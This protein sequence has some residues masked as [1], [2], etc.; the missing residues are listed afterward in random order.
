MM[1]RRSFLRLLAASSAALTFPSVVRAQTLGLGGG[2]APSN[3]L[4]MGFIG[5]GGQGFGV[6]N[7]F[8]SNSR[9]QGVAVCDVD[10]EFLKKAKTRID[11]VNKVPAAEKGVPTYADLREMLQ[12]SDIDA[13]TI[14]TP[15]HWHALA[16]VYAAQAGKHI[17]LEKPI[18][19]N[20][21][22]GRIMVQAVRQAGVVC[23]IGNQQRSSGEFIRFIDLVRNGY[24]GEIKVIKVGLPS[25]KDASKADPYASMEVPPTLD[26]ERWLGPAPLVPY[27]KDRVHFKWRWN[28]DYGGGQLTDWIGHHYDIAA[29]ALRVTDQQP[30]ALEKVSGKFPL[31]SSLNNVATDYAFLARYASGVVIDVSSSY[32]GGAYAEGTEGWM[33]VNR[34]VTDYSSDLLRRMVIPSQQSLAGEWRKDHREHFV[35]AVL[36]GGL[37]NSPIWEG[38]N[39]ATVAHLGNVALQTNRSGLRWDP[40]KEQL[41]DAPEGV[42]FLSRAYRGGYALPT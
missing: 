7:G 41:L 10:Q 35:D 33:H 1:Q 6:M 2:V 13:V 4:A 25:Q 38:H 15:D 34:G 5:V 11:E 14:C 31:N 20:Q 42:P 18:S 23:Q 29:V 32:K 16:T 27:Q 30:V 22:E 12:R 37:P 24:L 39:I 8:L 28:F 19:H 3:R 21:A 17:Y 26:Y 40:E 9:V 36:R